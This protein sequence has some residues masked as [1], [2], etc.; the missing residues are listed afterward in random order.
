[1]SGLSFV[2]RVG[3]WFLVLVSLLITAEVA[4]RF[5]GFGRPLLYEQT[6]YGYRVKP[7][8]DIKRFGNQLYYNK[9]GLRSGEMEHLDVRQHR[10][11][12]LGDSI[13]YGGV[14]ADQTQTYP[15]LLASTLRKRDHQVSVLNASAGGV[16]VGE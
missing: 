13:T 16:G 10:V 11:L 15:E 6:D 3:K 4:L 14:Q 5:Y 7:G 9:Q 2:V 8:Q 1:M 12:C